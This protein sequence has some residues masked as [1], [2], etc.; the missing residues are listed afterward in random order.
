[1]PSGYRPAGRVLPGTGVPHILHRSRSEAVRGPPEEHSVR[2]QSVGGYRRIRTVAVGER[3]EVFLARAE[4]TSDPPVLVRLTD[5][6]RAEAEIAAATAAEGEHVVELLDLFTAPDDRIGLVFPRLPGGTL[7][8]LL[9]RRARFAAG[10]ATTLLVAV[11]RGLSALHRAGRTHG[12]LRAS[13]VRFAEDGTPLLTGLGL[14]VQAT[15]G[16]EAADRA[17]LAAL[18]AAVLAK[19]DGGDVV[20]ARL[21]GEVEPDRLEALLFDAADPVPVDLAGDPMP[22]EPSFPSRIGGELPR[23][24]AAAATTEPAAGRIH[25]AATRALGAVRPRFWIAA[26]AVAAALA[27]ALLLPSGNAGPT[28]STFPGGAASSPPPAAPVPVVDRSVLGGEDP[29][30]A[31]QVLAAARDDCR[32][33][34]SAECL[35]MVLEPGSALLETDVAA[36]GPTADPTVTG[37]ADEATVQRTGDAAMVSFPA[38]TLLLLR[39]EGEWRLRDVFAA[40]P[41]S[42]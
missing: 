31:A 11:S 37:A 4:G 5:D 14:S 35:G 40:Q 7:A 19:T 41:P 38:G 36:L 24:G 13:R 12:S 22:V 34:Q 16:S 2:V 33:A 6:T 28:A 20:A 26:A 23:L 27:A 10:E 21:G 30:A 17:A 1:M 42:G 25:A 39:V 9:E 18:A 8:Q 29:V 15:P 3:G 32:A